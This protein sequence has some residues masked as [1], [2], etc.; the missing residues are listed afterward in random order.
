MHRLKRSGISI[1]SAENRWSSLFVTNG[2]NSMNKEMK[3][4]EIN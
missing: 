4:C 3:F 1:S 2:Y